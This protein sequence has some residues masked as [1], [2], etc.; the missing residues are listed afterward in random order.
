[1]SMILLM[2]PIFFSLGL[3]PQINTFLIYMLEQIDMHLLGG[4]A[5]CSL[6]SAFLGVLRSMLACF[7]LYGPVFGGLSEPRGTQHILFSIFCALLIAISYH[8]SRSASDF[9]CIW[10]LI[11]SS[12]FIHTDDDEEDKEPSNETEQVDV[13]HKKTDNETQATGGNV[14]SSTSDLDITNKDCELEDPLPRKLQSTVNSRLKNDFLVCIVMGVLVFSLHCTT[15]FTVLQP[16]LLDI[17]CKIAAQLGFV[18]HYFV[19]QMRKHL[20]WLCVAQPVLKQNEFG[21]FEARKAAKVMWFEKTYV[22]MCFFE[23]NILYPLLFLSALTENSTVIAQKFGVA[24]GAAI[25][26]ICGL[27]CKFFLNIFFFQFL[28][29]I[30]R[31]KFGFSAKKKRA[32]IEKL[33]F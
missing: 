12:L 31:L 24:F 22:C 2:M 28:K 25:I 15:V 30:V 20:P 3:F 23:K 11:K 10:S 16:E 29:T 13:D 32:N 21:Q 8:L 19:P 14:K 33:T 6:V 7:I 5:V 18:L 9:S 17:I 27:K 26:V 1:M 4:N